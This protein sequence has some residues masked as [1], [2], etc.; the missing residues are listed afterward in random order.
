M[1]PNNDL[2][3]YTYLK[4]KDAARLGFKLI[5][6]SPKL[7]LYSYKGNKILHCTDF[8]ERGFFLQEDESYLGD[9]YGDVMNHFKGA[10]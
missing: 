6:E 1:H 2:K 10:R 9:T 8:G 3:L 5:G 7:R 4:K